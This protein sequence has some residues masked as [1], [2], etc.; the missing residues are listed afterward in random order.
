MFFFLGSFCPEGW[1]RHKLSCIKLGGGK[2]TFPAAKA[3]CESQDAHLMTMTDPDEE[4]FWIDRLKNNPP[5]D[6][7][8]QDFPKPNKKHNNHYN[9]WVGMRYNAELD[10]FVWENGV[11]IPWYVSDTF[12]RGKESSACFAAMFFINNKPTVDYVS[13]HIAN[14]ICNWNAYYYCQ[15][16]GTFSNLQ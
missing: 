9:L 8:T 6:D 11:P 7:Q 14:N 3:D 1:T 10:S 16:Y 2:K 12:E 13:Y 5:V 4:K 15:S